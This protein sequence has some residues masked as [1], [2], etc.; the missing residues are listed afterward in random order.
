LCAIFSF[1]LILC[2]KEFFMSYELVWTMLLRLAVAGALGTLIG[3][4]RE[5]RAKEAGMRTHFLV[6]L[7]SCLIMI[8]SQYGFGDNYADA[9][10][11]A[12]QIVSGIGF[13]GA[14]AII[15]D[16]RQAVR[17]LTTAAGIWVSSGIAMTVA[18]G[19]YVIAA[20]A[21]LL[22]LIGLEFAVIVFHRKDAKAQDDKE[23]Q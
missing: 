14:G 6:A 4:E 16:R 8:V 19:M 22:S 10:R 1:K 3:L 17:G 15:M 9:S 21:T 20:A 23:A 7:G 11:V 18:A 12:A 2:G 5:Y 13:I